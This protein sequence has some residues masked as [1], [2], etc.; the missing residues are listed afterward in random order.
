MQIYAYTPIPQTVHANKFKDLSKSLIVRLIFFYTSQL[1]LYPAC[2]YPKIYYLRT[3][4][5]HYIR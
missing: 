2:F 1:F 4:T 3:N 5:M